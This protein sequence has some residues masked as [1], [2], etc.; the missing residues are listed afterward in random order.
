MNMRFILK[1]KAGGKAPCNLRL[2]PCDL[3]RAHAP[4]AF[5]P[6]QMRRKAL[7]DIGIIPMRNKQASL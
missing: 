6:G 2:Q 5:F 7:Q 3:L 1:I 4:T